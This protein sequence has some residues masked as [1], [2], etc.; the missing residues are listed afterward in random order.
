MPHFVK[1]CLGVKG[2]EKIMMVVGKKMAQLVD[3]K[4]ASFML[5]NPIKE[6][7]C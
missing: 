2:T 4:D 1:N 5:F 7:L 3:E 6:K